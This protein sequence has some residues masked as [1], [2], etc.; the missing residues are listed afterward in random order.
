MGTLHTNIDE[1]VGYHR[2]ADGHVLPVYRDADGGLYV[3]YVGRRF[4]GS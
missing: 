3:T 1:I 2:F 4:Y